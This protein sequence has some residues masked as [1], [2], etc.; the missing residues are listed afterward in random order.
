MSA[1]NRPPDTRVVCG[2]RCSWWGP[3]A[4]VGKTPSGLPCCPHCGSV[5]FEYPT[6]AEWWAAVE[7]H[8]T[9]TGDPEYRAFAEWC[10]GRCLG[11][12]TTYTE[13]RAMFDAERA[14]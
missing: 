4:D 8:A 9:E 11:W 14:S 1:P 5:L 3:I 6:E 13:A 7:R 10:R 12:S 2:A